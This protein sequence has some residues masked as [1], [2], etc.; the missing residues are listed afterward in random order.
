MTLYFKEFDDLLVQTVSAPAMAY[1]LPPAA[2][3]NPKTICAAGRLRA[4][5]AS[6]SMASRASGLT[7]AVTSSRKQKR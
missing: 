2:A 3:K 7:R 6:N 1:P 5:T 4:Q